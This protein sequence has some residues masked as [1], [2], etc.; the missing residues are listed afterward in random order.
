MNHLITK[1]RHEPRRRLV[2]VHSAEQ[3][4]PGM[5]RVVLAGEELDGFLSAAHDDHVK[6]FFPNPGEEKPL[7]PGLG[8]NGPVWPEGLARPAMRDYTPRHFDATRR[9]LTIDFALHATGPASDWARQASRGQYLGLGGPRGSFVVS[10]DFDW[11]LLAGDEAALP[12]IARRLEELPAGSKTRIIIE[13]ENKDEE[14]ELST[15]SDARIVWV[16]RN[17]APAGEAAPL[18]EALWDMSLP[19]GDGY[20]WVAAESEVA[21]TVRRYLLDQRGVRKDWLKAAGY[22]RKGASAVHETHTD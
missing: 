12:A 2:Q 14:Q 1:V 15:R 7:L 4:T 19:S 6:V 3:I 17:G 9:Q 11:Y 8:P 13:V 5:V 16:H 10:D 21:K 20:S 18:L 22:W